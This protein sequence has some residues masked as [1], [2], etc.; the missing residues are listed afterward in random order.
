MPVE[1]RDILTKKKPSSIALKGFSIQGII[2]WKH[3]AS[4]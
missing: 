1:T 2:K 4:T 3:G